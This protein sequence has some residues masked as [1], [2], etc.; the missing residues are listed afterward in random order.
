MALNSSYEITDMIQWIFDHFYPLWIPEFCFVAWLNSF[1]KRLI[2]RGND[3]GYRILFL[4]LACVWHGHM[5]LHVLLCLSAC[6]SVMSRLVHMFWFAI[7]IHI[8]NNLRFLLVLF[9]YTC[10]CEISNIATIMTLV[11]TMHPIYAI[12]MHTNVNI[13][14]IIRLS[15]CYDII[16]WQSILYILL[17]CITVC[18]LLIIHLS[19]WF[20]LNMHCPS[21][22][23][24]W[25]A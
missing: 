16:Y 6:I 19:C 10:L 18:M 11:C 24:R 14:L 8:G 12:D 20:D 25:H 21:H 23:C 5:Q 13:L 17:T 4:L 7:W 3:L 15:S 22:I 2:Y 1:V 9:S